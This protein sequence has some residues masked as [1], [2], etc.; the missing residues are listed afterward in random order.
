MTEAD[1]HEL[2][3]VWPGIGGVEAWIAERCWQETKA[4]PG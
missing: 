3:R 2:L 1:A 4:W